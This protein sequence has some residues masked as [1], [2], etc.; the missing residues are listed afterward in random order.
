MCLL[1]TCS[2]AGKSTLLNGKKGSLLTAATT[3]FAYHCVFAVLSRRITSHGGEVTYNGRQCDEHFTRISAF[4][5][6]ASEASDDSI[7]H[8]M[9]A[10]FYESMQE[11][12]FWGNLT[13]REQLMYQARLRLPSHIPLDKKEEKVDKVIALLNLAKAQHHFIGNVQ[14]G[15]GR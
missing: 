6:Q 2:G 9:T 8:L 10:A 11:D 12:M 7:A 14:A 13:V 5:Q 15:H 4:V 1:Q 3:F